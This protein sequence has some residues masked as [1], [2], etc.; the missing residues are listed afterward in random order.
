MLASGAAYAPFE[1]FSS[2]AAAQNGN[3]SI[4]DRG[5]VGKWDLEGVGEAFGRVIDVRRSFSAADRELEECSAE[6]RVIRRD[7]WRATPL[8][9]TEHQRRL[10][11]G[12]LD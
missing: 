12:L 3:R 6:A 8:L 10:I 2:P 4:D 5:D 1:N 9:P 11:A 7:N